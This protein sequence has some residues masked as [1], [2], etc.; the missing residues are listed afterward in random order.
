MSWF[1]TSSTRVAILDIRSS[2]I[3]AGFVVLH[4]NQ[5]PQL[6]Y[7]T[8]VPLEPHATEPLTEAF[9][10]TLELV[11]Q[12]LIKEGAPILRKASGSA[13]TDRALVS[14]TAPWQNSI[15]F[16]TTV[17]PGHTFVFT[18]QVLEK[19]LQESAVTPEGWTRVSEMVIATL[20]NGYEVENP[21]G[22]KVNRAELIMLSSSIEDSMMTYVEKAVRKA[23]H[24]HQIEFDAF[25][26][27]AYDLFRELYPHQRDFLIL[28]IGNEAM[29]IVLAKHGLLVSAA[30]IP[31]GIS[32]IAKAA[33]GVGISSAAV[34]TPSADTILDASR[35]SDFADKVHKAESEW[36]SG[37]HASLSEIAK[38]EP[39]P[40]SVFMVAEENVRDFLK[41][42]LDTPQLRS[43]WLTEEALTILP[44]LPGQFAPFLSPDSVNPADPPLAVLALTAQ[45]RFG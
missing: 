23:L 14:F 28:D 11:L 24:Q 38:Q 8:R 1:G 29:D 16:S 13:H 36:L 21:F 42:L 26:P 44:I 10:R 33:R 18:K 7:G 17:D 37:V 5:A 19:A 25:I 12:T 3:G 22:K 6:V 27:D 35:N 30:Q 9:A 2:S 41:N 43:L 32:G 20:L 15:V 34:P 31:Q 45:K 4:K 39:L 40:R